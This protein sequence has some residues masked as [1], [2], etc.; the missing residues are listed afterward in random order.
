MFDQFVHIPRPFS[1]E[2]MLSDLQSFSEL[3]HG[4]ETRAL[5]APP[6]T[7]S[8]SPKSLYIC[9]V[10]FIIIPSDLDSICTNRQVQPAEHFCCITYSSLNEV[11]VYFFF[12][13]KTSSRHQGQLVAAE[14][15]TT[16][17]SSA[18]PQGLH[19]R[20]LFAHR[21]RCRSTSHHTHSH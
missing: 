4:Q 12:T 10:R 17:Y 2:T 21:T 15:P 3:L 5:R 1:P 8:P 11:A 14:D 18:Q 6:N 9:G 16:I 13:R 20:G 7:C 19:L